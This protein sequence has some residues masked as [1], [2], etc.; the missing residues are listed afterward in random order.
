M[1]LRCFCPRRS[2]TAGD[3]VMAAIVY[4]VCRVCVYVCVQTLDIFGTG[5]GILMKLGPSCF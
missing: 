2:V 5:A 3:Y 4:G 1:R